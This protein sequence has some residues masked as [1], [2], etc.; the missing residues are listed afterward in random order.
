MNDKHLQYFRADKMDFK[1][2]NHQLYI[3]YCILLMD[4]VEKRGEMSVFH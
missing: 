4:G 2:N 3:I 1:S